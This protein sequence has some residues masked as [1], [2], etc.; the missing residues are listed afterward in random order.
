MELDSVVRDR[1]T[2]LGQ[3]Q[4]FSSGLSSQRTG[5]EDSPKFFDKGAEGVASGG[6]SL[7]FSGALK[8]SLS[9]AIIYSVSQP[10]IF[11]GEGVR[12]KGEDY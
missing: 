1:T 11:G 10:G 8:T 7:P 4:Q 9:G 2:S 5:S 6:P 12:L 3:G